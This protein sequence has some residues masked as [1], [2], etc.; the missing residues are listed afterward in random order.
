MRIKINSRNNKERYETG[1]TIFSG[2]IA[3]F[4]EERDDSTDADKSF[5][6]AGVVRNG[7]CLLDFSEFP[8]AAPFPFLRPL[9]FPWKL[10]IVV[11]NMKYGPIRL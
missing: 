4:M 10:L 5:P 2:A 3:D 11:L 8:L 7:F 1:V 6:G 9:R